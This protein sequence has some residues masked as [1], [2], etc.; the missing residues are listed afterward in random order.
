MDDPELSRSFRSQV[1]R[2]PVSGSVRWA[3]PRVWAAE[4]GGAARAGLCGVGGAVPLRL[5]ARNPSS[6]P[7]L[8]QPRLAVQPLQL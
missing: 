1:V 4:A 3:W 7:L 8:L 6:R 2:V 5:R